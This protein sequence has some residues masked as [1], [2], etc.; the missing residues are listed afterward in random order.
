MHHFQPSGIYETGSR[1]VAGRQVA[2]TAGKAK[3]SFFL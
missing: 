1:A 2:G 3:P